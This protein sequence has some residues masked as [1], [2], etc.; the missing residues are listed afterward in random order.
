MQSALDRLHRVAKSPESTA[1]ERRQSRLVAGGIQLER[2]NFPSAENH[3]RAVLS[4]GTDFEARL[5]LLAALVG[6]L[7]L[8]RDER[9]RTEGYE[10]ARQLI[11]DFE[12]LSRVDPR[13]ADLRLALR[14]PHA[15]RSL[16]AEPQSYGYLGRP[17]AKFLLKSRRNRI[18]RLPSP[19]G[20]WDNSKPT[21]ARAPDPLCSA[22][23]PRSAT[24]Q[25]KS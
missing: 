3:F 8:G 2:G 12:L 20:E 5:G 19:R 4:V 22:G 11:A 21:V 15:A 1:D 14:P 6:R 9:E 13:F 18:G 17:N 25:E 10:E 16:L 23:P 7:E 24:P